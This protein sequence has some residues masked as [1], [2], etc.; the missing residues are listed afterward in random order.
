MRKIIGIAFTAL[1]VVGFVLCLYLMCFLFGRVI[2]QTITIVIYAS[3][4]IWMAINERKFMP[5]KEVGVWMKFNIKPW[6][7]MNKAEID[8]F[9]S[10]MERVWKMS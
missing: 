3:L 10:A 2:G 4:I 6:K 9:N 1:I 7:E 8:K 5:S